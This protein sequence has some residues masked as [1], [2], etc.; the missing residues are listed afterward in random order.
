L[1]P[2]LQGLVAGLL[3]RL[4]DE[5]DA[6]DVESPPGEVQRVLTRAATNVEH[7]AVDRAR[8]RQPDDLRLRPLD[9]PGRPA[10]I[11]FLED[12]GVHW[13][14]PGLAQSGWSG[15][16][17]PIILA[18]AAPTLSIPEGRNARALRSVQNGNSRSSKAMT[19]RAIQE[20]LRSLGSPEA[21]AGAARF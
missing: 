9:V 6:P 7:G 4:R 10:V 2:A 11:R 14:V 19:A 3:D 12:G 8:F 1:E 13:G 18:R 15:I 21:A 20:H 5:V 16:D 17:F